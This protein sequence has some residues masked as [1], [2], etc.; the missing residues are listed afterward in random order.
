MHHLMGRE[1]AREKRS[2]PGLERYITYI[3]K[4]IEQTHSIIFYIQGCRY[5]S[6][7]HIQ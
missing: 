2:S 1:K 6:A 5:I 3:P 4:S 7:E